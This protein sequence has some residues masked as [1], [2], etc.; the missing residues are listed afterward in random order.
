MAPVSGKG[1]QKMKG[2]RCRHDTCQYPA[3]A[4]A[5]I[6]SNPW[7]RAFMS[8]RRPK[9]P[10]M[11]PTACR[12]W[13]LALPPLLSISDRPPTRAEVGDPRNKRAS[14]GVP[15]RGWQISREAAPHLLAKKPC[16]LQEEVSKRIDLRP[17]QQSHIP[18]YRDRPVW[19]RPPTIDGE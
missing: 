7:M 6:Q 2:C 16:P 14:T 3:G 12:R 8:W 9:T 5:C 13:P 10:V 18:A 11:C 1:Q 15:G 4:S 17:A 19:L